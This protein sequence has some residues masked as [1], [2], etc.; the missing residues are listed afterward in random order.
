M[1]RVRLGGGRELPSD[2]TAHRDVRPGM[3]SP[4]PGVWAGSSLAHGNPGCH[5]PRVPVSAHGPLNAN[6]PNS[7][8]V[9]CLLYKDLKP[10]L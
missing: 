2:H 6:T 5:M 9:P 7:L 3:A 1:N 4:E 10:L 8:S